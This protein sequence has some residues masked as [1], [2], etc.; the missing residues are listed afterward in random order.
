M[1]SRKRLSK[2]T[3]CHPTAKCMQTTMD[4]LCSNQRRKIKLWVTITLMMFLAGLPTHM[5][6]I[7]DIMS[8]QVWWHCLVPK[9]PAPRAAPA[10]RLQ[11]RLSRSLTRPR[12]PRHCEPA[13]RAAVIHSLPPFQEAARSP[14]P[15]RACSEQG[16]NRAAPAACSEQGPSR[17]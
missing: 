15:S 6:C 13:S 4:G 9:V 10:G 17:V 5:F 1:K 8:W 7:D 11:A 3:Y 2:V 14:T 16:P 12:H